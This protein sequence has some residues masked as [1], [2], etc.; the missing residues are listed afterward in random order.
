MGALEAASMSSQESFGMRGKREV[1]VEGD[2]VGR[3]GLEIMLQ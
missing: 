2:M 1:H 3:G